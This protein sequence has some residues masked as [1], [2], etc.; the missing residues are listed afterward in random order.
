MPM[1]ARP[2]RS[3]AW[4][5]S[6]GDAAHADRKSDHNPSERGIVCAIDIT[7]D[8]IHFDGNKFAEALRLARDPRVK[9]VIWNTR[10]YS[11]LVE[12]WKW[13]PYKYAK[14]MPHDH[15]VHVSV[16]DAEG[17]WVIA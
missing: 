5:G 10:I 17:P 15:H 6:I 3:R 14:E 4:D 16:I 9:Y 12:P 7:H 2:K 8:P 11:S 13:R 1:A